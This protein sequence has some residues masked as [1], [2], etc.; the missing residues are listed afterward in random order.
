MDQRAEQILEQIIIHYINNA[1]PI[2]SRLLSKALNQ[3]LSPATIRNVMADLTDLGMIEQPHT[4][5]G[6]IPTDLGYRYYIN[7]YLKSGKLKTSGFKKTIS[8]LE[9]SHP[10]RLEDILRQATEELSSMTSCTGLIISPMLAASRLKQVQLIRLGNKQLLAVI[11]TQIGMVH[12]KIIYVRQ[13]PEQDDLDKVARFLIDQFEREPIAKI[14]KTLVNKLSDLQEEYEQQFIAQVIRLGKN[15]FDIDSPG[16]LY[17]TGRSLMCSYP[18]FCNQDY[19]VEVYK[20]FEEKSILTEIMIKMMENEGIH[21][22]IGTENNYIGL[23]KC[24]V[25]AG[26]YGNQGYSLGSIGVVGP[27][28]LDYPKVIS[29]IEYS[30]RKLS[31]SL[32]RFLEGN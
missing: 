18:E 6:R 21:V 7:K 16:E 1:E 32:A 10:T 19:L 22:N 3:K 26:T 24:S 8:E 9:E 11:I 25:V 27:T 23:D 17:I 14:R 15:V 4:S 31:F 28:R 30:T 5:A 2:G 20:V 29:A 13:A 12:N